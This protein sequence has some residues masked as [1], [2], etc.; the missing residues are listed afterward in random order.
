VSL[1]ANITASI[2]KTKAEIC[3][4]N[5]PKWRKICIGGKINQKIRGFSAACLAPEGMLKQE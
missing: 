2:G 3:G 1:G 5:R 4:E